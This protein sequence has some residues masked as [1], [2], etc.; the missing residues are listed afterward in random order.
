M[1]IKIKDHLSQAEAGVGAELGKIL[2]SIEMLVRKRDRLGSEKA[3]K[4]TL[5]YQN[6]CNQ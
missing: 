3:M 1:K 5:L 2:L 6:L 4:L